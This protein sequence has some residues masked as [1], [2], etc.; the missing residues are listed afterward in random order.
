[1]LAPLDRFSRDYTLFQFTNKRLRDFIDPKHLLIQIDEQ[2]DFPKLDEPLEDYY[3]R[4]IG[5]PAV[6][7][8]VLVR[9]LLI[10]SLYK[11]TSFRR[12]CSAISEYRLPLVLLRFRL[13]W[14]Y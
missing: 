1:M 14:V 2:F 3:C 5:R 13:L 4:E 8:E 12:L 7:P 6:H 11:I 9:A 10:S